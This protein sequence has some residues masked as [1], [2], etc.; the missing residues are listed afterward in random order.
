M[1]RNEVVKGRG[2]WDFCMGGGGSS[3]KFSALVIG[4]SPVELSA[5]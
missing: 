1:L 5:L 2:F 3:I 4:A